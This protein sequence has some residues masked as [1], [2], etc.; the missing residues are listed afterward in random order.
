MKT[1]T[2]AALARP[3]VMGANVRWVAALFI[4]S[5]RMRAYRP[6]DDG[7]RWKRETLEN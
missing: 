2:R 3:L 7:A 6:H 5:S 4:I 1:K